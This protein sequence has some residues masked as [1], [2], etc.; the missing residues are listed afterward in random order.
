MPRTTVLD[1]REMV[2]RAVE[3]CRSAHGTCTETIVYGLE[4]GGDRADERLV[5]LLQDC[6]DLCRLTEDVLLR[7]SRYTDRICGLC[8]DSCE[9]AAEACD[10]FPDDEVMKA[11]ANETRRCADA[12]REL[13]SSEPR[14]P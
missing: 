4:L 9:D 6:A 13:V 1:R 2:D 12:S 8:A 7:G 10:A 14:S 3:A 5:T 11:C